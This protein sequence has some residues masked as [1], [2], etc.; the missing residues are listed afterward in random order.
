MGAG[1]STGDDK[2]HVATQTSFAPYSTRRNSSS[3]RCKLEAQ[4]ESTMISRCAAMFAMTL[5]VTPV[6]CGDSVAGGSAGP[7]SDA[8]PDGAGDGSSRD[9]RAQE[10]SVDATIDASGDADGSDDGPA[11]ACVP[12]KAERADASRLGSCDPYPCGQT[13]FRVDWV[14]VRGDPTGYAQCEPL[15][16]SCA[17]TTCD[18]RTTCSCVEASWKSETCSVLR[19]CVEEDAGAIVV[20]CSLQAPP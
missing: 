7:S 15:P 8:R 5:A 10:G 4:R 18:P 1:H 19:S 16:T 14:P 11:D 2:A 3:K 9:G 6:S 17:V 13:E 20:T 12:L